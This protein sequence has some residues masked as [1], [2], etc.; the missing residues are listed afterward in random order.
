M[1]KKKLSIVAFFT[2]LFLAVGAFH[3]Q[4]TKSTVTATNGEENPPVKEE[5]DE[6]ASEKIG[7]NNEQEDKQ[8]VIPEDTEDTEN[9]LDPEDNHTPQYNKDG[10]SIEGSSSSDTESTPEKE[11][12]TQDLTSDETTSPEPERIKHGDDVYIDVTDEDKFKKLAAKAQKFGARLYG[13]ENSDLFAFIKGNEPLLLFSPGTAS[14]EV[15]D[16]DV[17]KDFF[18][19]NE[20]FQKANGFSTN[21]DVVIETG[22][23]VDVE[24]SRFSGYQ[25]YKKDNSIIVNYGD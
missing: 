1:M 6:S 7:Q 8:N 13:L 24:F 17:L 2:V 11:D 15:E 18:S 25:I 5:Q 21:V 10:S 23:K 3:Y 19:G 9:A 14:A 22:A 16:I 12:P 20:D 4:G